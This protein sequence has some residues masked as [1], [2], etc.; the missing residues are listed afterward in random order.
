MLNLNRRSYTPFKFHR[1]NRLSLVS[2][3]AFIIIAVSLLTMVAVL[4]VV[5]YAGI[6]AWGYIEVHGMKGVV[7]SIWYGA[8]YHAEY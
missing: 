2:V 8:Q 5:G 7:E 6:S 1:N 4:V 3:L